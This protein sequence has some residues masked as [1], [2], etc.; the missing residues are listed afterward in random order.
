MPWGHVSFIFAEKLN[1][2]CWEAPHLSVSLPPFLLPFSWWET[3]QSFRCLLEAALRSYNR[4]L[5][6]A[7]NIISEDH[8]KALSQ[9]GTSISVTGYLN[10]E[11]VVGGRWPLWGLQSF[12]KSQDFTEIP[13]Q[14]IAGSQRSEDYWIKWELRNLDCWQYLDDR[15]KHYSC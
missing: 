3:L 11:C 5:E 4:M 9:A 1:S 2:F 10:V 15:G 12:C 8:R 7:Q 13:L 6:T 14:E